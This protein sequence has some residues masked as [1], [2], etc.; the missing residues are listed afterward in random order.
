MNF[1]IRTYQLILWTIVLFLFF[2]CSTPSTL[3]D[4]E[5]LEQADIT[6]EELISLIPDYQDL[7]FT[8][9][10]SGRAIVSEP[11]NNERV[12][13][14]FQSNRDE[15]F[16]QVRSGTGIEGGQIYVD[17]DSLMV[18]NRIDKIA[19]KI[20]LHEGNLT[21]V[22]SLA[23][24]NMLD[25]FNYTIDSATIEEIYEDHETESYVLLLV[26]RSLI[27]VSQRDGYVQSVVHTNDNRSAPYSKLEYEG[28]AVV[29]EFLLPRRITIYSKDGHS[30]A[31]LLV[32]RLNINPTLPPLGIDLPDDIPVIRL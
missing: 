12:S 2:G 4:I 17:R 15:S 20:P 13:L 23:S 10:G 3:A 16:I 18:Y 9:S 5:S 24:V 22:G 30:R 19:E 31:T 28:Y 6:T 11:G 26:N 29:E 7:L 1:S 27:R 32:Q 25:L 14:H 8:I 21:S